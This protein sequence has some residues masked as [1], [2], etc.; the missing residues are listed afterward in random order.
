MY[1]EY[2]ENQHLK[3]LYNDLKKEFDKIFAKLYLA[4]EENKMLL[5]ENKQL[6]KKIDYLLGRIVNYASR[7][8]EKPELW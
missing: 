6:K 8:G 7:L 1:P 4:N 3:E 5:K 2:D